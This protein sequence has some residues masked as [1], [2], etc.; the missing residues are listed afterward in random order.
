M[1][2]LFRSRAD[3]ASVAIE[4]GC[5]WPGRLAGIQST[6]RS[7]WQ[8]GA[9]REPD[10]GC[11]IDTPSR[12]VP[13]VW[14]TEWASAQQLSSATARSALAR[15]EGAS[16]C[17]QSTMV[18]RCALV[19]AAALAASTSIARNARLPLRVRLLKR[20]PALFSMTRGQAGPKKPDDPHW[21]NDACRERSRPR[22]SRRHVGLRQGSCPAVPLLHSPNSA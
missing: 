5:R 10:A 6:G 22:E 8:S 4:E 12:P 1:S 11:R 2:S 16:S 7:C 9:R 14:R 17:P 18:L 20:L 21:G 15:A 3:R 19:L 13:E